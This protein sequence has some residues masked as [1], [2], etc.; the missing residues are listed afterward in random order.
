MEIFAIVCKT[1][2]INLSYKLHRLM[3][4]FVQHVNVKMNVNLNAKILIPKYS[5]SIKLKLT[6]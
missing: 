1:K 5:K 4:D 3:Y 6:D 2:G